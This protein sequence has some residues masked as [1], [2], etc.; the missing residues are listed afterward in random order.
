[1]WQSENDEMKMDLG[2]EDFLWEKI[3]SLS[4][5]DDDR[6]FVRKNKSLMNFPK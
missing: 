2:M 3:I 1:M 4:V 6:R 5:S